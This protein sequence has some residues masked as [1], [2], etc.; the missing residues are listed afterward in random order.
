M[1]CEEYEDTKE[2]IKIHKSKK[3]R[4]HNGPCKILSF[5]HS[6]KERQIHFHVFNSCVA[7]S[8]NVVKL[9]LNVMNNEGI[10][11]LL[12]SNQCMRPWWSDKISSR[13]FT[14]S[15]CRYLFSEVGEDTSRWCA[16]Y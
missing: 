14:T 12:I 7:I 9:V 3:D 2:V 10:I 1:S 13:Y 5:Y 4:Q 11:L 16:R 15:T 6:W 8:L